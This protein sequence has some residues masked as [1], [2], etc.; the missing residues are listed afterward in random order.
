[1]SAETAP[2]PTRKGGWK[3]W[4]PKVLLTIVGL[5]V[6][7]FIF[8]Y[9]ASNFSGFAEGVQAAF[10]MPT[11]WTIAAIL[12]AIF[13][14]LVY[15]LTA[16]A[17]IPH[18]GY[19]PA[20]VDRQGGFAISTTIPF[21]GGPIA[22]GTQYAILARYGVEQRLAAAAVAADAIWTYLMT[23]GA[24][25]VALT[26]LWVFERRA[27][28][29]DECGPVSC[30]TIDIVCIVA[31]VICLVSM[32][33]IAFVLRSRTNARKVGEFAQGAIGGVFRF[34]K[35][36]PPNVVDSVVGFNDTAAE[37]VGKRWIPLTL[38]NIVAQ[39]APMFVI[40]A[41]LRGVGAEGLTVL[42][43]FTAFS[44]ALVLTTVPLAPGGAGTVDA[45]L[46]GMLVA[47]GADYSEA[48]AAD[49]IWRAFCF[50]PQML[51]GW[52]A[53]GVFAVQRR[54][55]AHRPASSGT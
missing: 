46:I 26:L 16:L 25:G 41:A 38:T 1:M 30:Q 23:F 32:V 5:A 10:S 48:V 2:A 33:A 52:I 49:V 9:M 13:A 35:R 47:F 29:G 34:I 36:T 51:I 17:A 44:V 14:I 54:R 21:G 31:G 43:I 19:G 4:L 42:E 6:A 39:L 45:A 3:S 15:P 28:S 7:Y 55:S 27:L 22:V 53:V 24:P 11:M 8:D 37:M 20:F 12:A 50:L 40:V 18:L